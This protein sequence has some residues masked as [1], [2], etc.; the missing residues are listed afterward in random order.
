MTLLLLTPFGCRI[1]Q[2]LL[3]SWAGLRGASSIVFAITA[4]SSGVY[5]SIDLFH[6]VFMVSLFSIAIQGALLPAVSKKLDMIDENPDITRTFSDY[7][8]LDALEPRGY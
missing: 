5:L 6:V 2:C 7:D 8:D 1:R 4:V 3:I